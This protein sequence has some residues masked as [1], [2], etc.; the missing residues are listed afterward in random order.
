MDRRLGFCVMLL[1]GAW[2]SSA[3]FA[4]NAASEPAVPAAPIPAPATT[5]VEEAEEA[6][7][8]FAF[9]G[10]GKSKPAKPQ[11]QAP[12]R[13]TIHTPDPEATRLL[14]KFLPLKNPHG[15]ESL[16][17]EQI[18]YLVEETPNQVES[19]LNTI[20]WFDNKTTV[21]PAG[22]NYDVHV[23][24]GKRVFIR[25]VSVLLLGDMKTDP[26][27][28]DYYRRGMENWSAVIGNP[29]M[30]SEWTESKNS[31]LKAVRRKAYPLAVISQSK[32]RLDPKT[33]R[34]ELSLQ[35]DSKQKIYFGNVEVSGSQR[36]TPEVAKGLAQF[37]FGDVYDDDKRIDYQQ[38]L[39]SDPH[40][41][42]AV[43]HPDFDRLENDHVPIVV[44][45]DENKLQKLD[46]G[47][48][49]DSADGAGARLGY[50]YYNLF[51]RGYVGSL[52][53]DFDRYHQLVSLGISQ[54]RQADGYFYTGNVK[55]D[56]NTLQSIHTKALSA[57]LWRVRQQNRIDSRLGLEY[58]VD[59]SNI[60]NG[61]K[62][63][64]AHALMLTYSW[65]NNTIET[66]ARPQNGYFLEAKA[67]LS[68]GSLLS[69]A[70]IQRVN[71]NAAYF[72]T[73]REHKNYGTVIARGQ[74]GYVHA[75]EN[76]SVPMSLLFR[77]GGANSVRGYSADSIG[78]PISGAMM[79]GRI[80][81]V[82]GVEYQFPIKKDY[83][84]AVFHDMGG[85]SNTFK[86]FKFNHSTGI[87]V[88]WFSPVAPLSFDI[89]YAHQTRK[90][91]W[92]ISLGTHF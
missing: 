82:A 57:G 53:T 36:Y 16:D 28:P 67:G 37:H 59:T 10:F 4:Q 39:E 46:I 29:F 20:G 69:S 77:T 12:Y 52:L 55:F 56:N 44:Q 54:P 61:P 68:F 64:T 34:G 43:V 17:R 38:A 85:V 19:L 15:A 49:Y 65:K 35:V 33:G 6:P 70:P 40:F 48:R 92:N 72:Y 89:A 71:I 76:A 14:E 58:Y 51:K 42:A 26:D 66:L 25:D 13:V 5:S 31:I 7:A 86:T 24:L 62:F 3:V 22:G 83:A 88:R 18:E 45:V 8:P 81:G 2:S 63:S 21:T 50:D 84:L 87:G 27:L 73:P 79:G 9:L 80:V 60:V 30:Q 47:L 41:A 75:P 32:A 11:S 23:V 1:S 90:F 91:G 74:F 78:I